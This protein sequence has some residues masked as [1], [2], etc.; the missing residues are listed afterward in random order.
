MLYLIRSIHPKALYK[1]ACD[2]LYTFKGPNAIIGIYCI[3]CK[4]DVRLCSHFVTKKDIVRIL[5]M[6]GNEIFAIF[7]DDG[8]HVKVGEVKLV[9]VVEEQLGD[10]LRTRTCNRRGINTLSDRKSVF[11]RRRGRVLT[12]EVQLEPY[13]RT[14]PVADSQIVKISDYLR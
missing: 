12:F 4:V 14:E 3:I 2:R 7:V 6:V 10:L 8:V 11:G 1:T 5:Q 13:L 9:T